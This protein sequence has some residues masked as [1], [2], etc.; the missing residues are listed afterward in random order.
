MFIDFDN[1]GNGGGSGE[2]TKQAIV[3]A[4]GYTPGKESFVIKYEGGR[5][6]PGFNDAMA[7]GITDVSF[8]DNGTIWKAISI[9]AASGGKWVLYFE[10][11]ETNTFKSMK[12]TIDA[13]D[14]YAIDENAIRPLAS[15]MNE[16][17]FSFIDG[18]MRVS[19]EE[20]D[21]ITPNPNILY[22]IT[23]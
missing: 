9:Q 11:P 12:I 15:L 18:I 16:T 7:A 5:F 22:I 1:R 10:N 3:D 8:V 6:T 21:F 20:Y 4:L 2:V 17:T 13:N 14:N 23:D 19:Q